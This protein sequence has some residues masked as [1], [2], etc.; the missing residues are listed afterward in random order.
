LQIRYRGSDE[1][2]HEVRNKGPRDA[3]LMGVANKLSHRVLPVEGDVPRTA[4]Q[5]GFAVK[6]K[7]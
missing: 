2:L 4:W 1:I 6:R 5:G 3:L 7:M